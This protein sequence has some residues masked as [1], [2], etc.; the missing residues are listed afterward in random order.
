MRKI[1]AKGERGEQPRGKMGMTGRVDGE[2]ETVGEGERE[3]RSVID[4]T[5]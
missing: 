1:N 2:F 5:R 3:R 4:N